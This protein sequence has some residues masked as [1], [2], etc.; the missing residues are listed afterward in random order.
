MAKQI[1]IPHVPS[2]PKEPIDILTS[3]EKE[4]FYGAMI[5]E[6]EELVIETLKV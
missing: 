4:Y 1:I 2:F 6:T 3:L 5:S